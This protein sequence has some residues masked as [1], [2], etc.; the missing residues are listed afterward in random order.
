MKFLNVPGA[1]KD[2]F[3]AGLDLIPGKKL[4]VDVGACGG[5]KRFGVL[6]TPSPIAT[7][8]ETLTHLRQ[9][10]V[11]NGY[12]ADRSAACI[13]AFTQPALATVTG[14]GAFGD[15]CVGSANGP[16]VL[17]SISDGNALC[18]AFSSY[19]DSI[20]EKPTGT[21]EASNAARAEIKRETILACCAA[22]DWSLPVLPAEIPTQ[23]GVTWMPNG[24]L[25]GNGENSL[26]LIG[27][28]WSLLQVSDEYALVLIPC[29]WTAQNANAWWHFIPRKMR[30][31]PWMVGCAAF[32]HNGWVN[33]NIW[34]Y[35]NGA[36]NWSSSWRPQPLLAPSILASKL[37]FLPR[38]RVKSGGAMPGLGSPEGFDQSLYDGAP[39][40]GVGTPWVAYGWAGS[41]MALHASGMIEAYLSDGFAEDPAGVGYLR[42]TPTVV[43]T[44]VTRE[45][46]AKINE[47]PPDATAAQ[48]AEAETR[49]ADVNASGMRV[50]VAVSTNVPMDFAPMAQAW[51]P[52]VSGLSDEINMEE[53]EVAPGVNMIQAV[54]KARAMPSSPDRL[55]CLGV[56]GAEATAIARDVTCVRSG[57]PPS[58]FVYTLTLSDGS[59]VDDDTAKGFL[60]CGGGLYGVL[61]HRNEWMMLPDVGI[62]ADITMWRT[63][64][65]GKDIRSSILKYSVRFPEFEYMKPLGANARG[66]QYAISN[67]AE[68][69]SAA[70][71][72]IHEARGWSFGHRLQTVNGDIDALK[73]GDVMVPVAKEVF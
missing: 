6:M 8:V 33:Q 51:R 14:E 34:R 42:V 57:E 20:G 45:G 59:V 50:M 1:C 16:E 68:D 37:G 64:G 25:S 73:F 58:S 32:A 26:Y 5:S 47:P 3:P 38:E 29:G 70:S 22:D 41:A 9:L 28:I 71:K 43:K 24:F 72:Q 30:R 19:I 46:M 52:Y 55:V 48:L 23:T 13:T 65:E 62:G 40:T 53:H 17:R 56:Q 36:T 63:T 60:A 39:W 15:I 18:S 66:G 2:L 35:N 49:K 31:E 11:A 54:Q 4:L 27:K 21:W 61:A 7:T 67:G 69:R 44:Y 10:Y 12:T